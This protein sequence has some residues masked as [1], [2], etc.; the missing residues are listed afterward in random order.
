M[1]GIEKQLL[2]FYIMLY[3]IVDIAAPDLPY[4]AFFITIVVDRVV[5]H[6][7]LH[8]GQRNFAAKTLID[9]KFVL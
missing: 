7:R 9:R 2:L 5:L 3:T 8:F 6:A 1:Y 4:M